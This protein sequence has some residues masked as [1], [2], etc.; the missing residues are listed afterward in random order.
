MNYYKEIRWKIK[1]S[2]KL[3][4]LQGLHERADGYYESV[5]VQF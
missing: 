4:W 5:L 2:L 1:I 3:N